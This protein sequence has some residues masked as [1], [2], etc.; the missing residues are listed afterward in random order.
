[1]ITASEAI[2]DPNL[3][4][5]AF[6]GESWA[7]WRAVLRAAEGL[8]LDRHQRR[9]FRAIAERDPPKRRVR[10]LWVVAGRRAGKD[11]IASA[12]AA[13]AAIN[14][15]RALLRPGERATV[16]CLACDRAQAR[17]VNRYVRGYFAQVPLLT[18][19]VERE[20]DDGLE[21][22]NGVEIVVATNSFRAVRGRTII[23]AIFDEVAFWRDE[24]S[25]APDF[26]T[27]AAVTPGTATLANAM[28]IG[29]ST[30]YRRAGLM[31]DR[32]RRF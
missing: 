29:I 15:C 19:L 6:A 17:I 23:C 16:M 1:M 24:A 10:E 30:P 21:L 27:Y 9:A 18:P 13:A 25:A 31:F 26:E 2:S 22:N 3:L 12:I 8:P 4:G 7:T 28:L 14:D 20:T 11:S 5:T 32:W